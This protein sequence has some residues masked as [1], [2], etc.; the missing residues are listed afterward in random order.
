M[1]KKRHPRPP[2][3]LVFSTTDFFG[4][5]VEL[6]QA[7]WNLHV[8]DEHP[9]MAGWEE[10]V[11]DVIRD[12]HEIRV[13]TE[14]DTGVAFISDAGVGPRPEGIRALVAFVDKFYEKGAT[15]GIVVTAYP[16]DIAKYRNPHLGKT[17]YKKG[18]L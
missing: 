16:V 1:S 3:T 14:Y 8:L 6:T 7:T 13:S 5:L 18:R 2:E 15:T 17:I 11:C 10:A 12:P 4:N 9:Q